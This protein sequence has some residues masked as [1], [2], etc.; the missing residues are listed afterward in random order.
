MMDEAHFDLLA[1][2]TLKAL[3]T[4]LDGVDDIEAE[5]ELGVLTISFDEGPNFVVNSH[6]A[7]RQIWMAADRTAW[8][9]D[10]H[11]HGAAVT[12]DSSKPP[13]EELHAALAAALSR[14]LKRP[15]Q[16]PGA[17]P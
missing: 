5:L 8:H 17:Q 11:E 1:D 7:A 4:A 15:V 16:L 14:R 12:W 9:F 6:R 10:P 13:R 3:V 2:R